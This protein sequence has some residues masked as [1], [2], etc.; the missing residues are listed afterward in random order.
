MADYYFSTKDLA[1][2]YNGK[3]LMTT[4]YCLR[5][6]L[7]CCLHPERWAPREG[8]LD[9][10]PSDSLLLRNQNHRFRLEFDCRQCVMRIYRHKK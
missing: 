7:G 10:A 3:A 9:I 4:K 5:H 2:G 8:R 1:V 6:E